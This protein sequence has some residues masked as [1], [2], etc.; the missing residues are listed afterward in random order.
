[1]DVFR[2]IIQLTGWKIYSSTI[3]LYK[4]WLRQFIL[5]SE[6]LWRLMNLIDTIKYRLGCLEVK[7]SSTGP[8]VLGSSPMWG[9]VGAH[10][11]ETGIKCFQVFNGYLKLTG[12]W[13]H[14]NWLYL[15][16]KLT[17][18]PDKV[19]FFDKSD[20]VRKSIKTKVWYV[21]INC[22]YSSNKS[23]ME[24]E[25]RLHKLVQNYKIRFLKIF[26]V[27]ILYFFL[28]N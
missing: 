19:Y 28:P 6:M 23:S 17:S 7:S 9:V 12:S 16:L 3:Q 24:S 10:Q 1:M 11:D 13:F 2:Q 26:T 5:V 18:L 22:K 21:L 8:N 4:T 20:D 15:S 25:T 27:G 14:W